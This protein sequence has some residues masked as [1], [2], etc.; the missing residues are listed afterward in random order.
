MA[1]RSAWD[2]QF[3]DD[4]TIILDDGTVIQI[5]DMTFEQVIE[6][7]NILIP[8]EELGKGIRGKLRK[9]AGRQIRVDIDSRDSGW[10]GRIIERRE[11]PSFPTRSHIY[12]HGIRLALLEIAEQVKSGDLA[13]AIKRD[14]TRRTLAEAAEWAKDEHEF[15]DGLQMN[16]FICKDDKD[17]LEDLKQ[18]AE[19]YYVSGITQWQKDRLRI[20]FP[21]VGF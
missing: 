15:F 11:H 6:G 16:V 3:E 12:R 19:A 8:K 14:I 4:G 17:Q 5:E 7:I 9:G 2:S 18:Q 10:I 13:I 20:I 1:E 21:D